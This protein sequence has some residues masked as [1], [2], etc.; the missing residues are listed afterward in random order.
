MKRNIIKVALSNTKRYLVFLVILSISISYLTIL[1]SLFVKYAVD[2]ILFSN[3]ADIPKYVNMFLKQNYIYDLAVISIMIVLLNFSSKLLSYFRDRVTTKFKL[4]I[5]TNLKSELYRHTLKLEYESYNMYDKAEIMQRINE[6][7][8]VYSKFF[9]NQFNVILDIVFLSIFII[10]QSAILNLE[11]SIYIFL[12][13]ALMIMFSGWYFRKLGKYIGNMISKRK[14]LLKL[15]IR[16]ISNFKFVRMFNKQEEE[17]ENYK[18]LNDSYSKEEIIFIKLVLFYDIILEHFAY[19][20]SPI[21]YALG[22]IAIIN[23]KNDT[24]VIT[25]ATLFS[26]KSF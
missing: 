21:I 4:K 26:R 16:N 14:E 9:N 6:D 2:G 20:R 5:N 25:C 17:K 8:D 10:R 23:R 19:L 24:W 22:G 18:M 13:I 1:I 11:I 12:T 7:A 3:Y 15:T